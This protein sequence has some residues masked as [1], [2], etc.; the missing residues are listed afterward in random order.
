MKRGLGEI[1]SNKQQQP[2]S[3]QTHHTATAITAAEFERLSTA[4]AIALMPLMME[5]DDGALA[6]A[7]V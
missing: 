2:P 7:P 4:D 6:L 1:E 5:D 3:T